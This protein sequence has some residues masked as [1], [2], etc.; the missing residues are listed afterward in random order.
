MSHTSLKNA[1]RGFAVA[2]LVTSAGSATAHAI[3]AGPVAIHGAV[4]ATSAYSNRYNY[5]G[6]TRD[7]VDLNIVELTLNGAHRFENGV[8]LGAQLYAYEIAGYNDLALDFA[9][10]DY[11]FKEWLGIRAGRNKT[12]FGLYGDSQDV[13]VIRP[14]AFLPLDIYGKTMRPLNAAYDGAGLYGSV[15][16]DSAG[17]LDYQVNYGW[18]PEPDASTPYLLGVNETGPV[19]SSSIKPDTLLN[20]S[21]FWNTP[22][23]GLRFGYTL[24]K[25][26]GIKSRGRMKTW[27]Q[28]ASAPSAV[29][30]LAYAFP[31]AYW[32]TAV[33]GQPAG[34]EID[35][36]QQTLS[37]EYTKGAWQ[38]AAEYFWATVEGVSINPAPL[39]RSSVESKSDAYYGMVTWQAA[40][41]LQLGAYYAESFANRDDRDGSEIHVVPAHTAYLKDATV[42]ASYSLADWW[43]VKLEVHALKGTKG[44]TARANGDASTWRSTWNYVV[45]K[46]TVSF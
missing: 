12:S 7:S 20:L 11:S 40:D 25:P 5:L 32:D 44:I 24:M 16:L 28:L 45:L 42:A 3:D 14:F 33:A 18:I 19:A 30:G 34:S 46:T 31:A 39:G 38:F 1:V 15:S 13:D 4:S 23:E 2:A 10:L 43:L 9:T 36:P 26:E 37:A 21:L 29:R 22:V 27:A 8:R 35:Y 17:T 6:D 41:K